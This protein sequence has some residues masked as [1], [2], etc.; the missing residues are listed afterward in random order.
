M[1][2]FSSC[3]S[4]SQSREHQERQSRKH[5]WAMFFSHSVCKATRFGDDNAR[6]VRTKEEKTFVSIKR[7]GF[8]GF[9]KGSLSST[10]INLGHYWAQLCFLCIRRLEDARCRSHSEFE[11]LSNS[12]VV[13]PF[14]WWNSRN[15]WFKHAPFFFHN[16]MSCLSCFIFFPLDSTEKYRYNLEIVYIQLYMNEYSIDAA[17]TSWTSMIQFDERHKG[18]YFQSVLEIETFVF[19]TELYIMRM[20]KPT[21]STYSIRN[22]DVTDWITPIS[23]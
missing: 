12:L 9:L 8:C 4:Q 10:S 7:N 22:D 16:G 1:F 11:K 17:F 20:G 15:I 18:F 6:V 5:E 3:V 14:A 23:L 21:R 2:F 19:F 13:G